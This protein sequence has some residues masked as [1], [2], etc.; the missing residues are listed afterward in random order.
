MQF[1]I[2]NFPNLQAIAYSTCSIYLRENEEV[3]RNIIENNSNIEIVNILPDWKLRGFEISNKNVLTRT[4]RENM[5]KKESDGFFV[6][7]LKIK[8]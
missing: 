7:L 6:A 2:D 5:F 3:I 4:I 8:R 1:S